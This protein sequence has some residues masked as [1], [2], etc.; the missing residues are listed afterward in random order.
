[1]LVI[2]RQQALVELVH[3]HAMIPSC[4]CLV[5]VLLVLPA[6]PQTSEASACAGGK[7]ISPD[8]Q[9]DACEQ[10]INAGGA[11]EDVAAALRNRCLAKALKGDFDVAIVDCDEA[12]RLLPNDPKNTWKALYDRAYAYEAKG[13]YNKAIGDYGRLVERD[14]ENANILNSRGNAY[15]DNGDYKRAIAD[16]SRSISLN[17]NISIVGSSLDVGTTLANRGETRALAGDF[18][19]ALADC[20]EAIKLEPNETVPRSARGFV[21]LK[22]E[23]FDEALSDFDMAVRFSPQRPFALYGRGIA[24]IRKGDDTGHADVSAAKAISPA[25]ENY[26]AGYGIH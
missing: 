2:F 24:K 8:I 19:K 3:N 25:I 13:E 23:K 15:R 4:I 12:L 21:Y 14:P 22:M 7:G 18:A 17:N 1:L 20:N 10:I 11:K 16:Y 26:F 9:I 6:I 5:L